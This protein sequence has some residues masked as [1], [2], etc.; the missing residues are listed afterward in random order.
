MDVRIRV[1]RSA[2]AGSGVQPIRSRG[3]PDQLQFRLSNG[4]PT[5]KGI[6]PGVLCGR[7][8]RAVHHDIVL[9]YKDPVSGVDDQR[10]DGGQPI[11]P[12]RGEAKD[13]DTTRVRGGRCHITVVRIMDTVR[14]GGL[15]GR[16]RSKRIHHAT[17]LNGAG[18]V[19]QGGQFH[20]SVDL[21]YYAPPIQSRTDQTSVEKKDQET[22]TGLRHEKRMGPSVAVH[23]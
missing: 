7:V 5:G 13:G 20:G 21:C 15:A 9:L 8:V 10:N 4:R 18:V 23:L 19:L 1:L 17:G 16:F 12:G 14:C 2:S 22:A 3:V 6:H 11:W